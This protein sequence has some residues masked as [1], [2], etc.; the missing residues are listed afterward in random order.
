MTQ[1]TLYLVVGVPGSGKTWVCSQLAEKF[2]LIHHD[3]YIY[4]KT[5]GAYVKA[6]LEQAP[7]ILRPILIEAPF[8]VSETVEPLEKAGYKITPFFIIEEE[9]VLRAR[10]FARERKPIPPGH[11]TRTKTYFRRAWEGK[12]FYGTSDQVLAKLLELP[13]T[14]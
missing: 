3:G 10:Y 5:P 4:L 12:H 9:D 2:H 6:I 8:S 7:T 11:L 14:V 13:T 1:K